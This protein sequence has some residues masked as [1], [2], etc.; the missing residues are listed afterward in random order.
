MDHTMWEILTHIFSVWFNLEVKDNFRVILKKHSLKPDFISL[1]LPLQMRTDLIVGL[2][3]LERFW[4][5][6]L[7]TGKKHT[8][9]VPSD[10]NISDLVNQPYKWS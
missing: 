2:K 3:S 5:M 1:I 4:N 6:S 7:H 8:A 10:F 9:K